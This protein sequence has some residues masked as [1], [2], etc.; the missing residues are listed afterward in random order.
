[1]A[2]AKLLVGLVVWLGVIGV[3]F[4][5]LEA[6]ENR[7]GADAITPPA[8]PA[9][10]HLS[11]DPSRPTLVLF[12]HPRCPC[13]RASLRALEVLLRRHPEDI[14]AYVLL[15]KPPGVPDGWE[16][17]AT[18]RQAIELKG[19]Q[20]VVDT[21]DQE[22]RTFGAQTSGQVL[23][24]DNRGRL[25]YSGGITPAR[26]REGANAGQSAVES[27]L[28]GDVPSITEGPVF[29]CPLADPE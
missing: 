15:C 3:G 1:M 13:S 10:S 5:G 14:C 25:S 11:R 17:S 6:Y 29:G 8:W 18:W 22:R 26:G 20:L 12:L 21:G 23:L 24:F 9:G 16:E 2:R 27:L 4:W 19:V 28:R 7:P